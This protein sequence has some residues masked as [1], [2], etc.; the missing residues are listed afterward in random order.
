MSVATRLRH[1]GGLAAWAVHHPIGIVMITLAAAV[2]GAFALGRLAVDLLPS[3]IYPE[4]G[5]RVLDPG[6]PA[7]VM[8]DRIT[9]QLEEQLAITEDAIAITS[10]T[11]EGRSAVEL[12]FPYGKDIDIALRDASTRLDRARR[13]LPESIQPPIIFKRDP[14]QRPILEL[15]VSSP[16]R[17]PVAL[18]TWVDDVY[19]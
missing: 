12:A 8:E 9:R 7:Q 16:T 14:S 15:V 18:R 19:A 17:D 5:I 13:F 10:R 2:L 6:V 11:T 3:I 1:G 4:I